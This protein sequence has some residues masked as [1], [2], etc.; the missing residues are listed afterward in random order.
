[1]TRAPLCLGTYPTPLRRVLVT[2]DGHGELWLKDDG[3]TN[4]VYG[5]NKVRKLEHLIAD[6]LERG[7]RCLLTFGAA[8]SH[9]VYATSVFGKQYGL[10][11]RAVLFPQ[12]HS[13][14]AEHMLRLTLGS[15]ADCSASPAGPALLPTLLRQWRRKTYVIPPGGSSRIGCRGYVE[16]ASELTAQLEALGLSSFDELVVSA[17]SGGT[18]AGLIAGLG[19]RRVMTRVVAAPVA[20]PPWGVRLLLREL[21]RRMGLGRGGRFNVDSSHTGRGYGHSSPG[22]EASLVYSAKIGL[23]TDPTYTAK[24]F[25]TALSRLDPRWLDRSNQ[26]LAFRRADPLENA[27]F[28]DQ[29]Q[30]RFRVLYW[31]TLATPTGAALQPTNLWTS[32][33]PTDFQRLLV[34]V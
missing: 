25:A 8:G 19:R 7:C 13:D 9:H 27:E 22:G 2:Q 23:T 34:R 20:G 32:P 11:V 30:A 17:G 4:S 5:G 31:H 10:D 16:A 33:L 21:V 12:P 3:Q 14:H 15:G 28:R 1:M 24:A 6:A 26:T 29:T 18:A